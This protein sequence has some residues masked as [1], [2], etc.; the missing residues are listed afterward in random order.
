MVEASKGHDDER[1]SARE[2]NE[3]DHSRGI[4]L[5]GSGLDQTLL[6]DVLDD[7]YE[8]RITGP[9]D[10][11]LETHNLR[12]V[13]SSSL[14]EY[15][16]A[17][18]ERGDPSASG[19]VPVLVV[20][21]DRDGSPPPEAIW[22]V[23]DDVIERP[24][25][26]TELAARVKTLLT[27]R[28]TVVDLE[29][30]R[31][32]LAETEAE[33]E[34]KERVMDAAPV[35]ITI[36]DPN[37][38]DNPLIYANEAFTRLTGYEVDEVVGRNCRFLQGPETGQGPVRQMRDAIRAEEAVSVDILN[39]RQDGTTFWNEV[40]IAP[41]RDD[42][43]VV[44]FVGFQSD[45]TERKIRQQRLQVLN[46]LMTHNL[47]NNLN[48]LGGYTEL[49]RARLDDDDELASFAAQVHRTIEDL[50][51]LGDR[52][53]HVDRSLRATGIDSSPVPL[54]RTLERMV[55]SIRETAPE[56]AV[57]LDVPDG[58]WRVD[59]SGIGIAIEEAVE[60]ALEHNDGDDRSLQLSLSE[61][62]DTARIRLVVEDNGPG[63][64]EYERTV[65]EQG[66]E[67]PLEHSDGIGL[68]LIRWIVQRS[69][70]DVSF[71]SSDAD[72]GRIT[73]SLPRYQT[74]DDPSEV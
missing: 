48:K 45:I 15:T 58:D 68:W 40:N 51:R 13:D 21:S 19:F 63:F 7:E 26:R 31:R 27:R 71:E 9:R 36:S 4:L 12:I 49:L 14:E 52:A 33:L 23:A 56:V 29:R 44:N 3:A 28:R 38:D 60:N 74:D 54:D 10:D 32:Q 20:R 59:C 47:R 65:F 30:H 34:L 62:V 25:D 11:I 57:T 42:G 5:F 6:T 41:V 2:F 8:I 72:G 1:T 43:E 37:R 16:S 73:F 17:V 46:R 39:Y 22:S 61:S 66:E 67:T 50:Q 35:G 64:P 18:N 70:G 55:D 53:D 24:I 69:G